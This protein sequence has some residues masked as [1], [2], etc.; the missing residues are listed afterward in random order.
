MAKKKKAPKNAVKKARKKGKK[1][2]AVSIYCNSVTS[3][4]TYYYYCNGNEGVA[5]YECGNVQRKVLKSKVHDPVLHGL[6][7]D[8]K[9]IFKIM[10]K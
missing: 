10:Y 3:D 4:S 6:C 2:F 5:G 1:K 9:Q 7:P 8:G